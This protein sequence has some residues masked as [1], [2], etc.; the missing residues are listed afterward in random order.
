MAMCHELSFTDEKECLEEFARVYGNYPPREP[1]PSWFNVLV[2]S[3]G[4]RGRD[5]QSSLR[6]AAAGNTK[7][8]PWYQSFQQWFDELKK[9]HQQ[10]TG[11]ISILLRTEPGTWEEFE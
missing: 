6:N 9:S 5:V 7:D 1:C 3:V 4:H 8:L 2:S 11:E 10:P